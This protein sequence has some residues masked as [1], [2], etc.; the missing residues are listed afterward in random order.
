MVRGVQVYTSHLTE[1]SWTSTRRYKGIR[2]PKV[3]IVGARVGVR[4]N[5]NFG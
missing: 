5:G 3:F 4:P 1:V 2:A